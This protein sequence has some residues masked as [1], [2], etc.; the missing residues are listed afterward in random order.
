[1]IKRIILTTLF[2]FLVLFF[3]CTSPTED[4]K[5]EP[6]DL[7]VLESDVV[8]GGLT[9]VDNY[10]NTLLI[11]TSQ[12]TILFTVESPTPPGLKRESIWSPSFGDYA[13]IA[14]PYS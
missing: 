7:Y 9:N 6:G 12:D 8:I 3:S 2:I 11:N 5:K 14:L 4:P 13:Y 1:M 10:H